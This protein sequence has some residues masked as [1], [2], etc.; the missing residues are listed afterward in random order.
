MVHV[1]KSDGRQSGSPGPKF[2]PLGSPNE[3]AV[4]CKV[5][6]RSE[7]M[8][9]GDEEEK[10]GFGGDSVLSVSIHLVEGTEGV[11][12][13]GPQGESFCE[14]AE[15]GGPDLVTM[16][17]V[18]MGSV[19]RAPPEEYLYPHLQHHHH[20][21]HLGMGVQGQNFG[22]M[23]AG[24]EIYYPE[25]LSYAAV[26]IQMVPNPR[27]WRAASVHEKGNLSLVGILGSFVT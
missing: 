25:D 10:V 22:H 1:D 13:E 3:D 6:S 11:E 19:M 21:G 12:Q 24:G 8:G 4:N 20:H 23:G 26:D 9:C 18:G 2:G 16:Q 5:E 17:P 15:E 14:Q 7:M 27:H